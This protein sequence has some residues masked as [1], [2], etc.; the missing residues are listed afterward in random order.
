MQQLGL[1]EKETLED[2]QHFPRHRTV[3]QG[4]QRET[5]VQ[6]GSRHSY[7][8]TS[9]SGV[10]RTPSGVGTS[11][12][13]PCYGHRTSGDFLQLGDTTSSSSQLTDPLSTN[14]DTPV[15]ELEGVS[16]E[17]GGEHFFDAREAHS[18]ENQSEGEVAD[19]K[20]EEEVQLR[21][22]GERSQRC[23]V[24][25][26][27]LHDLVELQSSKMRWRKRVSFEPGLNA[28]K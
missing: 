2:H 11:S 25:L 1:S 8:K 24:A 4:A 3:S 7:S 23:R 16:A 14:P 21:I 22:S 9:P 19:R 18:D 10:S 26:K 20:E 15:T 6:R 28:R 27:D 12:C 17:D 5:G 13:R